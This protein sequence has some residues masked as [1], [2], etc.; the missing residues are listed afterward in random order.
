MESSFSGGFGTASS[1]LIC[2]QTPLKQSAKLLLFDQTGTG[3]NRS[4]AHV[5]YHLP[6]GWRPTLDPAAPEDNRVLMPDQGFVVRGA[7][8]RVVSDAWLVV[9]GAE[10]E[11]AIATTI[12]AGGADTVVGMQ[13]ASSVKLRDSGLVSSGAFEGSADVQE[14]SRKD[15]LRVYDN[16]VAGLNKEPSAIYFYDLGAGLWRRVRQ[17]L[18]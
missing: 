13:R 11:T 14:V 6:A 3:I 4:A 2:E 1:I 18:E 9:A 5:L 17:R 10:T 12:A 8:P 7:G 16:A 15:E